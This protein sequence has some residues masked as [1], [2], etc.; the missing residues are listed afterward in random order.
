L[1]RA[2]RDYFDYY[3]NYRPHQALERN[4]P[5]PREVEGQGHLNSA[6]RWVASLLPTSRLTLAIQLAPG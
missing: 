3:H 5:T 2:L 1:R 4:S 6:S